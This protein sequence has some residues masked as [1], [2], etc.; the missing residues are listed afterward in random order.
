MIDVATSDNFLN[1][2]RSNMNNMGVGNNIMDMRVNNSVNVPKSAYN[3]NSLNSLNPDNIKNYNLPKGNNEMMDLNPAFPPNKNPM[4]MNINNSKN[5]M[6][7]DN[8]Q[9]NN[10]IYAFGKEQSMMNRNQFNNHNNKNINPS[11]YRNDNNKSNG[12]MNKGN[13]SPFHS[14]NNNSNNLSTGFM[15][16]GNKNNV[17]P[18]RNDNN[19]SNDFNNN[20]QNMGFNNN[21]LIK[22]PMMNNTQNNFYKERPY[23]DMLNYTPL[24]K[25]RGQMENQSNSN[26]N[27]KNIFAP[28]NQP[29]SNYNPVSRFNNGR[30]M[31]SGGVNN[32]NNNIRNQN[33]NMYGINNNYPPNKPLN[34]YNPNLIKN[35]GNVS[36]LNR[37][38]NGG[39]IKIKNNNFINNIN[40][41]KKPTTPDLNSH[42]NNMGFM[43]TNHNRFKFNNLNNNK[44]DIKNN[45]MSNGFGYTGMNNY[46][47]KMGNQRPSTAPDK[48]DKPGMNTNNKLNNINRS[49][50]FAGNTK[51]IRY[52]QRPSSAGGKNKNGYANNMNRNGL[53]KNLSNNNMNKNGKKHMGPGIGKRLASPQIYPNSMGY[54]NQNNMRSKYNPAKHRMPSPAIK[55][56]N[57][58]KRPPLPNSG[59]RINTN[60]SDKFN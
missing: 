13:P 54:N 1:N 30:P 40:K 39:P 7:N 25:D 52:N 44:K 8:N 10:M 46:N 24:I 17:S 57:F 11:P 49:N 33:K 58:S 2:E 14:D 50:Q 56:S 6:L 20:R 4:M 5:Q 47:K 41:N 38:K 35:K 37:N 42:Y 43:D 28:Q 19:N 9:F 36:L 27:N 26:S 21:K 45:T 60:K 59:S 32:F 22:D 12:F 53:G 48:G 16:K 15:N 55:S 34:N 31:N 29:I 3:I 51:P 23:D 18:F